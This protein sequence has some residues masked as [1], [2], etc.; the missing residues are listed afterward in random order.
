[1][2]PFAVDRPEFCFAVGNRVLVDGPMYPVYLRAEGIGQ[3][4]LGKDA[5]Q[6]RQRATVSMGRFV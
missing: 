3:V 5:H 1:M 6:A 4:V 2:R